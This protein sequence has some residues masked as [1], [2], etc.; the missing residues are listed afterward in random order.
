MKSI[1]TLFLF[2]SCCFYISA[3]DQTFFYATMSA[4]HAEELSKDA[5]QEIEIIATY[6]NEAAVRLTPT[7]SHK[8]HDRILTHGPGYIHRNSEEEAVQAIQRSNNR[9]A[10][11]TRAA[12]NFSI[13]EDVVVLPTLDLIQ[14]QNI[15]DHIIELENYGTRH[16]SRPSGIQAAID[17][18]A[19]WEAMADFY[20]RS[21]VSVR[22][23]DHANTEMPSVILTITGAEFPDEYVIVGGH[24]DS[25][26]NQGN[27]D[28]APGADDDASGIA[29]ITEATRALFEIGFV[30]KRTIEVMAYAAEEVGLVGSNEIASEYASNNINVIAVSQFD[31]TLLNGS[32]NDVSFITD[33]TNSDLTSYM[34]SLLDHYNTAAP[35]QIT[36]ST[37]VCNYGCSDH[38]SWTEQGYMA[39]FPFEAN[40]GQH[41][42]LIH[43]TGDTFNLINT[44]SHATK[45]AKLCAEFLIEVAKND[46]TALSVDNTLASSIFVSIT[47]NTVSYDL[48]MATKDITAMQLYSIE[49]KQVLHVP[50]ISERDQITITP[51]ASGVY[52][53]S[54]TTANNTR[55]SKK[56]IVR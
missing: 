2:V 29:T 47:D 7:G 35:H 51:L 45:F 22:L 54:F 10:S 15:E 14:T 16:H 3:Q 8:L 13:T 52:I 26:S 17:L 53:A 30:P 38:A 31:M 32:S 56:L 34:M 37:S 28:N 6:R 5:P 4:H 55:V 41:N 36:Y 43:T 12:A 46:N 20:N 42:N 40:F 19:T 9:I 21:D 50:T 39:A 27:V 48:S 33:F 24:L 1:I 44:A 18:K 11:N 23:Y 25:T 49:G